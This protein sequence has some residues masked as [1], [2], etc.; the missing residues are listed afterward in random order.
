MNATVRR[1]LAC[2]LLACLP[3][4]AGA[5]DNAP[6][7]APAAPAPALPAPDLNLRIERYASSIGSDGVQ[8]ETRY[9]D[10]MYRRADLVWIER[11]YPAALRQRGT[12]TRRRTSGP[13]SACRPF[14]CKHDGLAP[15]GAARCRRQDQVRMVLRKQH[16]VL[17]IDE[18]N[19]GNVGYSNSWAAT[20][21]IAD[22]RQL[23]RM[24][25][26]GAPAQGVQRYAGARRIAGPH[27]LGYPGAVRA[28]DRDPGSAR[29]LGQQGH[30]DRRGR[31]VPAPWTLLKDYETGDYSDLLD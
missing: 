6:E 16:K 7:P 31:A 25:P 26:D 29:P 11:D 23:Q 10:L 21:G 27:R 20:Y 14:P 1:G 2:L 24:Q 12:W 9:A 5:A 30:G 17:D 19:Y 13:G 28:P 8:R 22:P 3:A 4:A 15:L 18:A